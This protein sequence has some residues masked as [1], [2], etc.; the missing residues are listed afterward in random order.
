MSGMPIR[1]VQRETFNSQLL[2]GRPKGRMVA[3]IWGQTRNLGDR[4]LGPVD[5][6][7][8]P[9]GGPSRLRHRDMGTGTMPNIPIRNVQR[10]TFNSQLLTGR[11][12]GRI[13]GR[14]WGQTRCPMY[15]SGTFN[16]QRSTLNVQRG[17]RKAACWA[18]NGDRHVIW[19]T[20]L[21]ARCTCPSAARTVQA[22]GASRHGDRH[23]VRYTDEE[24]STWNV[25]L[26][27]FNG[28]TEGAH[29]GPEMGT[30]TMSGMPIRNVQR[31]T[32]N[33]QRS[34]G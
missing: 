24:R 26:S 1:N 12:K 14:K 33:S 8:R 4:T 27:T 21:S 13:L 28:A 23:D 30:D 16:V 19:T 25:Q 2:T 5:L 11:P 17:D 32:F 34:R 20:G 7:K 9:S 15:R 18:G 29:P 22:G 31:E 10:G 3:G 6:T